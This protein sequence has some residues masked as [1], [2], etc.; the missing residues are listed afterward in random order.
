MATHVVRTHSE[1]RWEHLLLGLREPRTRVALVTPE[2]VEPALLA[3][4]LELVGV[5]P[6]GRLA[7]FEREE[8]AR[9]FARGDEAPHAIDARFARAG[10][11]VA[12]VHGE[13][14]DS[15][16]VRLLAAQERLEDGA[17][18]PAPAT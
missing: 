11:G 14:A 9:A 4:Y 10:R 7:L 6:W 18:H 15:G 16:R 13:I 1:T 8:D 2:P 17:R 5:G 3:Y 12:T